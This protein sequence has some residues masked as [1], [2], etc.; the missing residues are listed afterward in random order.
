MQ[1]GVAQPCVLCGDRTRGGLICAACDADL[2]RLP[3]ERCPQCA[4]PAFGGQLC[5]ACLKRPPAFERCEA[6][7]SYGFPLDALIRHCK[8][9]G[10]QELAALFAEA[11]AA[12]LADRPLPELIVPMP[13]H[14]AR[15]RERGFNQS[16]EIARRLATRLDLPCQHAC[17]RQRDT[18]PQAGLDLKARRRN[19]RGAFVCDEAL[20]GKRIA[21]LDDV[22][23]SGSSLNELAKAA[24][25]AGAVEVDVWVVARTL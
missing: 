14:P 25:R 22:M 3:A 12:R 11:L 1:I 13:L 17:Q 6:V 10:A 7:F 15:L 2:P 5:G 19:L 21:L 8:Y 4:L 20:A 23:T 24:R 9:A 18:P 16:L